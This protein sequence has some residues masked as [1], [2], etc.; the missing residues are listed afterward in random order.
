MKKQNKGGVGDK[1]STKDTG[2]NVDSSMLASDDDE[3]PME[4]PVT[5]SSLEFLPEKSQLKPKLD[6]IFAEVENNLPTI[7]FELSDVRHNF[8]LNQLSANQRTLMTL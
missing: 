8:Y 1:I 7:N 3:L 6:R 2:T 4:D 5:L